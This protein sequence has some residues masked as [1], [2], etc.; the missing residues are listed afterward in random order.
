MFVVAPIDSRLRVS[1][2]CK[3]RLL[4]LLDGVSQGIRKREIYSRPQGADL[5]PNGSD[6]G[7]QLR[8]VD[9]HKRA[10]DMCL[11]INEPWGDRR[12]TT[13]LLVQ[14]AAGDD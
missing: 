12:P 9:G 1:H 3:K 6:K 8:S 7:S 4:R 5:L 11:L 14:T 10:S 13:E 2:D